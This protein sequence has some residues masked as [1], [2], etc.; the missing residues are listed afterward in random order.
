M[1][2]AGK[3]RWRII[4]IATVFNLMFEFSLRGV[5]GIVAHPVLPILLFVVY[6]TY[7]T[8]VED[9]ILRYRLKDYHL[10][11]VAFIFGTIAQFLISG[12]ALDSEG[13]MG[14]NWGRFLFVNLVWWGALQTILALYIANRIVSR[15]WE[16]K[17]V[18]KAGWGLSLLI[19]LGIIILFR[20]SGIIPDVSRPAFWA[21][22]ISLAISFLP[23]PVSIRGRA[24]RSAQPTFQKS[25]LMDILGLVTVLIFVGS[26]CFLTANPSQVGAS[27]VGVGALRFVSVWT[28]V[29][30]LVMLGYRVLSR[31]EISV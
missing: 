18:S 29:L 23:L 2:N 12:T 8:I 26:G 9:L 31:R 7:F 21:M 11:F 10:M 6:F 13:A 3:G 30:G 24:A 16:H 14:V 5:A 20:A 15:N 28:G 25:G 17:H 27:V 4:F 1:N 19:I 22:V